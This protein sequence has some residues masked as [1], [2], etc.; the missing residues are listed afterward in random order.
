MM[1]A[2]AHMENYMNV[3]IEE[4]NKCFSYPKVGAVIVKEGRTISKA[5]KD[6]IKGKHAERIAIE[7]LSPNELIG[8]TLI[9]TLEPCVEVY[10]GQDKMSCADLIIE[11]QIKEVVIGVLDPHGQIYCEGFNKLTNAGIKVNFFTS[12]LREIIEANTFKHGYCSIGYGPSGKRWVGVI[13]S[14]GK[15]FE[16]HFSQTSNHKIEFRWQT[17]QFLHGCVDLYYKNNSVTEAKGI[18]NFDDISD[19]LIFRNKTYYS[20]MRKGDIA[21]LYAPNDPF[22]T[23]IKLREITETDIYFQWQIRSPYKVASN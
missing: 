20:R 16:I 1:E 23:L 18:K 15:T 5:H 17:I 10:H 7:K 13:G 19:P 12:R 3:A 9:T 2:I 21:V 6:E 11:H 22:I 8:S 4:Q 14:G